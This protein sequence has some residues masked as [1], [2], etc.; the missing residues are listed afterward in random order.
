M[1]A[2]TGRLTPVLTVREPVQSAAWYA[3]VL[4]MIVRRQYVD[5]DG[6]VG[7]VCL[8]EPSTGLELCLVRHVANP[9]DAF[10]EFRTG[11][12]HLEFR[13]ERR[14]DLD[15]WVSRLDELSVPHSGIKEPS[16]TANAMIT[17]RD[18]DNIQL[19]FF[20]QAAEAGAEDSRR[21]SE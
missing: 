10:S 19:E 3:E 6:A 9:G 7:D 21:P 2:I 16:Y 14:A 18:P 1:P 4:G 12:D 5:P 13:V 8:L 11:L 20:W 17:F 15:D